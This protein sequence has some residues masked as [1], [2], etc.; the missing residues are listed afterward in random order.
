MEV[1]TTLRRSAIPFLVLA[2]P[3]SF[4]LFRGG[5][6]CEPVCVEPTSRGLGTLGLIL[7]GTW[8]LAAMA[9]TWSTRYL[10]F[11]RRWLGRFVNPRRPTL[12]LLFAH[13]GAFL[14]FL[15]LDATAVPAA[16]WKP[17]VLPLSL[18]PFLPVWTLYAATYPVALI[19]GLVGVEF[20]E[21]ATLLVRT[22]V[23]FGGFGLSAI[24]QAVLATLVVEA[25][26]SR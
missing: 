3:L 23:L 25:V 22:I 19:A 24:W 1:R 15:T 6:F 21:T 14:C 18:V 2:E 16:L 8:V 20:G 13:F 5:A 11:G 17:I 7:V 10:E 9:T 4:F 12:A 26:Q